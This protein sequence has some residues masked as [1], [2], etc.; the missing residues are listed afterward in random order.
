[1]TCEF[2]K[3]SPIEGI[4]FPCDFSDREDCRDGKVLIDYCVEC[5]KYKSAQDAAEVVAKLTGWQWKKSYDK[6]DDTS[7]KAR[8]EAKDKDWYRPYFACTLKEAEALS[9]PPAPKPGENFKPKTK[10][11]DWCKACGGGGG[12]MKRV[13][14][15]DYSQPLQYF[16]CIE[17]SGAGVVPN[18]EKRA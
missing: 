4:L 18:K 15:E 13:P 9:K 12:E 8:H 14:K 2:C 5:D 3:G 11:N 6:D 10:H 16:Q 1:M 7:P 17:C